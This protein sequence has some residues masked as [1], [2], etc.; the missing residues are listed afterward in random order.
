MSVVY[1]CTKYKNKNKWN[2]IEDGGIYRKHKE[3]NKGKKN[4]PFLFWSNFI[5]AST[6]I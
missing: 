5:G 3:L 6:S 1:S 4:V 2:L